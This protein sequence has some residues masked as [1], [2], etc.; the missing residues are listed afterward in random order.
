MLGAL[1]PLVRALSLDIAPVRVNV[2]IPGVVD[3]ELWEV[4]H[5]TFGA[6]PEADLT[7]PA[8]GR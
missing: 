2:V 5:L 4:C 1:S 7:G 8:D 3:T 6:W